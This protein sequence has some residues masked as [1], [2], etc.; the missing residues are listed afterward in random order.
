[1]LKH[2]TEAGDMLREI[3]EP[4]DR[5]GVTLWVGMLIFV[6]NAGAKQRDEEAV[7]KKVQFV[8]LAITVPKRRGRGRH[9]E[10]AE[11]LEPGAVPRRVAVPGD[12]PVDPSRALPAVVNALRED[13]AY[14]GIV[15][16]QARRRGVGMPPHTGGDFFEPL[17]VYAK[18]RDKSR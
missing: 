7:G 18:C 1:M 13:I 11:E 8:Q 2:F 3:S 10:V 4:F 14:G 16:Q 6:L 9:A 5:V 12:F 15:V 17:A